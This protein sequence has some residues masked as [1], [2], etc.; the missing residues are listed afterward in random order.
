MLREPLA[1]QQTPQLVS[2][3]LLKIWEGL[4]ESYIGNW[5]SEKKPKKPS[6]QQKMW[7]VF[8]L[9]NFQ[10][11]HLSRAKNNS[12]GSAMQWRVL[13]FSRHGCNKN[14]CWPGVEAKKLQP[15]N[16]VHIFNSEGN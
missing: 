14:M 12:V 6:W 5:K 16:Q 15:E 9:F 7:G 11:S 3:E 2:R 8:Y 13:Q 10:T 4:E 1:A